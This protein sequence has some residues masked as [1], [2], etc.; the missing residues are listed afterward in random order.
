[1]ITGKL[2]VLSFE[3]ANALIEAAGG[4]INEHPS[5]QTSYI[6]VGKNPGKKLKKSEKYNTPQL[7]EV[8]LMAL[9]N[10]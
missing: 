5:S 1:V 9:L 6:V 8:E 10:A 3:Q 4:Q 2:E 7:S